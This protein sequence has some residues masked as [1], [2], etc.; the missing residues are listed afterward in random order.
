MI[1]I[2][3]AK[4]FYKEYINNYDV[5]NPKI[6]L[7]VAHIY[8]TAQKAKDLAIKLKL[9]EEDILLAELIGLLHDIGRFEQVKR[10]NTFVDKESINHGEFGVKILFEDNLIR[11]FIE[12]NS[13]DE[14]I[15]K[16]IINHN[17]DKIENVT[18]ERILTH[19]KIIRDADKM[20][21]FYIFIIDKIENTF[22]LEIWNK[23]KVTKEIKDGF[24]NNHKIDYQYRKTCADVLISAMAF[25]FDL[26]YIYSLQYIYEN[27]YLNKLIEKYDSRDKETIE[28]ITQLN[29]I[30]QRFIKEKIEEGKICLKNY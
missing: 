27:D 2:L 21:I 29:S 23:E 17:K 15:K 14:I 8:R 18:D 11:N 10:Y 26:N 19:C 6:A 4:E 9:S 7:K 20:D 30:A 12:D 5:Q 16:A 3:K 24:I 25:V 28:D 13:Y 22:P 1:D